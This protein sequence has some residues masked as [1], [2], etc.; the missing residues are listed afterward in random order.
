MPTKRITPRQLSAELRKRMRGQV[1]AAE[2]AAYDAALMGVT[3]AVAKTNELGLV[4]QSQYKAGWTARRIPGGAEYGNTAPHAS[5]IEHGRRPGRAGPPLTPIYE[6]VLRKLVPNGVVS[7]KDAFAMAK[8][9]RWKIHH[10]G[11]KPKFVLKSTVP[12]VEARFTAN[13]KQAL[14]KKP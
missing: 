10:H 8:N 2:N 7:E 1:K 13:I 3:L 5:V 4:D 11:S 14:S 6:W 12:A 9:I